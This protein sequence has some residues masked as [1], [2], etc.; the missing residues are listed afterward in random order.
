MISVTFFFRETAIRLSKAEEECG[1][2][3]QELSLAR[4]RS[5]SLDADFHSKEK[6]VHQLRTKLAV[7][8][9]VCSLSEHTT[10]FHNINVYLGI[11]RQRR[12]TGQTTRFTNVIPRTKSKYRQVKIVKLPPK[13]FWIISSFDRN[14][15][16]R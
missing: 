5:A 16:L 12:S 6:A 1:R 7:V 14:G 9:Q 4:R 15:L 2:L 10:F 3:Q 11:E 13:C 8:E